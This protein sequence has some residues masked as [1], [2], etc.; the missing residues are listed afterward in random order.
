[1]GSFGER[2]Q[3]TIGYLSGRFG[4]S[5]RDIEEM[6]ETMFHVEISL[7][8]HSSDYNVPVVLGNDVPGVRANHEPAILTNDVPDV[9]AND[10]PAFLSDDVP[11]SDALNQPRG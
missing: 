1:V 2:L 5:Q 7:G 9:R 6:L 3:A 11:L 8:C 10:A 4:I